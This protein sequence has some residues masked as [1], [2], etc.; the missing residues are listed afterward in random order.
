MTGEIEYLRLFAERQIKLWEDLLEALKLE[1]QARQRETHQ[2]NPT[3]LL[4]PDKQELEQKAA[5]LDKLAWRDGKKSGEFILEQDCPSWLLNILKS[6]Q[7][8]YS[9]AGYDYKLSVTKPTEQYPESRTFVWRYH[10]RKE[11][12][13]K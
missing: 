10:S 13:Q 2:Q 12:N 7:R 11:N 3:E 8:V 1:E 4:Q 9:F 6:T 5:E